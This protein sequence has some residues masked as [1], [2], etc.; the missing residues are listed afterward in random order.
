[1]LQDAFNKIQELSA[2]DKPRMK[3]IF[4]EKI[5]HRLCFMVE[6]LTSLDNRRRVFRFLADF[7][8]NQWRKGIPD[9]LEF[10]I[11]FCEELS[12]CEDPTVRQNVC[13]ITGFVLSA[14]RGQCDIGTARALSVEFRQRLYEILLSRQIDKSGAVRREVILSVADI[15]DDDIP[16]DFPEALERSPKDSETIFLFCSY[17]L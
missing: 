14:G 11:H 8:V 12:L 15:Q 2:E 16:N 1:M 9:F 3:K 5:Q 4:F 13:T 10:V 17:A 7:F 6:A